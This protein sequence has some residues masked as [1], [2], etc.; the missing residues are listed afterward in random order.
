LRSKDTVQFKSP[1]SGAVVA[2]RNQQFDQN[3][4]QALVITAHIGSDMEIHEEEVPEHA[5]DGT[6]DVKYVQKKKYPKGR[7]IVVCSKVV[8]ESGENPYDDGLFPYARIQNYVNQRK[9]WGISD[10]EQLESPQK[11][12]NKLICFSLDVLTLMGNPIW[13]VGSGSGVD[14]D[15]L[16]NQ[17]GL[18]VECD[19]VNQVQREEGVQLQPYVLQLVDRL[20]LW[21]DDI[22]GSNDVSRGARPEGVTAASAIQS[23]QEAANIRVRQKARNLDACLQNLGQLYLS[24]IFQFYSAP[25]VFRLT[26]QDG[27]QKFF[28]FHV[29]TLTNPETNEQEKVAH[30]RPFEQGAD[31]KI[32]E[33]QV[34]SMPIKG[35]LDLKVNTGST[36]SFAKDAIKNEAIQ[37]FDRQII[38]DEEVLKR[39][40]YPNWEAVLQRVNE[41]KA[42]QAESQAASQTPA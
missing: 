34:K 23:L 19:D 35:S 16:Y 10:I 36:L 26:N 17:P 2:D 31:G 33:G 28:K 22:S 1:V 20:K 25:R 38:D 42:A 15:N 11:V 21:F 13:K 3:D 6:I 29:E 7:K 24:R 14:T 8:L 41:K 30:Y 4:S 5:D 40:D 27:S 12:F 18:I 9:F 39:F 32:Y 37:L